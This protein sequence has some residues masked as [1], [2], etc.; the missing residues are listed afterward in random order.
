MR[1]TKHGPV[2]RRRLWWKEETSPTVCPGGHKVVPAR[3]WLS[4][5]KSNSTWNNFFLTLNVFQLWTE[6]FNYSVNWEILYSVLWRF[7]FLWLLKFSFSV[8]SRALSY[9]KQLLFKFQSVDF[10]RDIFAMKFQNITTSCAVSSKCSLGTSNLV[11]LI[12]LNQ[13]FCLICPVLW[14]MLQT[15]ILIC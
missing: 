10:W 3:P 2:P 5:L 1:M 8:L 11:I 12:Y 7:L 9:F 6:S 4:C 14:Q 15:A 13:N